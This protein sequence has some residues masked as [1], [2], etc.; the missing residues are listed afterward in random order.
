[1]HGPHSFFNRCVDIGAVAKV[2]IEIINLQSLQ[3][4]MAGVNNVFT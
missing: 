3:G 2:K 1:M 4:G